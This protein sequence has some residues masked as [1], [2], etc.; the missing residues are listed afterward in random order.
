M[1]HFELLGGVLVEDEGSLLIRL[2]LIIL[3]LLARW[4]MSQAVARPLVMWLLLRATASHMLR[5]L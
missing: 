1:V 2:L 3:L 5:W 4:P